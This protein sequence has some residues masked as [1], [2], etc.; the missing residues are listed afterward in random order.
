VGW[1][2]VLTLVLHPGASP[3]ALVQAAGESPPLA[4]A[5]VLPSKR[6]ETAMGYVTS[7]RLLHSGLPEYGLGRIPSFHAHIV[8]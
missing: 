1:G 2:L 4:F 8:T 7:G 3:G 6:H 5:L